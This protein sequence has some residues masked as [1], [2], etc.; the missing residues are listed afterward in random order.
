MFH[1]AIV[2][3]EEDALVY[4]QLA[5]TSQSSVE[6]SLASFLGLLQACGRLLQ[7]YLPTVNEVLLVAGSGS[8]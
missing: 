6:V 2:Q 5:S 3:V 8:S 1:A 4:L 7:C